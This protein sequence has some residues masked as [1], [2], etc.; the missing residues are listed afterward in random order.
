MNTI[1]FGIAVTYK[2]YPNPFNEVINVSSSSF[3]GKKVEV[4]IYND[5]GQNVFAKS[6]DKAN[7]TI[8]I[9]ASNFVTGFYFLKVSVDSKV[10]VIKKM[11][12]N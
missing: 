2:N 7:D 1:D 5:L 6:Y 11:I 4:L 12:K 10:Q 3:S 8:S 9:N